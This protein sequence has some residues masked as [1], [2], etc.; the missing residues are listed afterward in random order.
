MFKNYLRVA[1]RNIKNSKGISLINI[2][3]LAIGVTCCIAIFLYVK[4]EMS[5]DSFNKKADQ[6]Y[7]VYLNGKINGRVIKSASSTAPFG[8]EMTKEFPEVI[9]YARVRN[10]GIPVVR[11]NNKVFSE[12]KFYSVDSTFF[13][14]FTV[15]FLEGDPATALMQPNTVV[16]TR[17]IAQKYFGNEDPIGKIL[18]TDKRRDYVVT[19]VVEKWPAASHFHFDFLASLSSHEDS[20]NPFWLSNNFYTYLLLKKGTDVKALQDKM[21]S[22]VKKFAAPQIQSIAG[23][24]LEKFLA[25]GNRYDFEIQPLK[26]IHLHSHLEGEIEPN[27]DINYIYIF[28]AIGLA[29]L[30]IACINFMNLSTAKSEKRAKEVGIR[31][32]LGSNKIQLIKQFIVESILMS[33]ISV[34]IS[35]GLLELLLPLFNNLSGKEISLNFFHNLYTIPLLIAFAIIVGLI[36]GSYPAFILSSFQPVD[37]LKSRSKR[38][39]KGSGL[40]SGLVIFQFAISIILI[41]STFIIYNQL[42]YIRNKNLGFNKDHVLIISRTDDLGSRSET[43]QQELRTNPDIKFTSASSTIPGKDIGN[44]SYKMKGTSGND[45]QLLWVLYTDYNYAETYG[46]KL[47]KGRYFSKDHPSDTM[48]VVLNEAAVKAFNLKDPIGKEV[49]RFGS[50]K[51]ET[52]NYKIIGVVKDFNYQSLHQQIR[53]L[54]IHMFPGDYYGRFVS[55]R[56]SSTDYANTIAFITKTWKKFAGGEALSYNFFDSQWAALYFSEQKTGQIATTFSIIAIFI[57]CL[58]LL[59]LAAFVAEQRTKEIG[60]RKVL[61]A[62]IAEIILL[63]SKE[64]VKWVLIANLVAWPVAYY[65]MNN[66]LK[67][68]AYRIS[69]PWWI[70]PAAGV[71][72]FIVALV[73]VSS[74]TLKASI[75]NPVKA[76]KYE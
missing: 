32:T 67:E 64:F 54:I 65:F 2:I 50:S 61:G 59:G 41:I 49:V 29:I 74:Q 21:N 19:G 34:L 23:I 70:F 72:A 24:S 55:A 62:S 47:D 51:D 73:T 43:F 48:S 68:F 28:S 46:L 60:I 5:Y 30:L 6:I 16:I 69:M 66:W 7:R 71:I 75:S 27:S 36:A 40:R 31:K 9:N 3:G 45:L 26:S 37:A 17:E 10:Y 25:A 11:F 20:R 39:G 58:G 4:N 38:S 42:N 53:P 76:L 13:E 14:V 35:L 22:V 44:S 57:A 1:I 63:L 56:I 15:K 18:N 12:D 52:F 8:A 33:I